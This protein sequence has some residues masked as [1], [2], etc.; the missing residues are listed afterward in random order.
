MIFVTTTNKS[1][2]KGVCDKVLVI[3]ALYREYNY[4][5]YHKK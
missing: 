1:N 2:N 3:M 5:Q 4:K